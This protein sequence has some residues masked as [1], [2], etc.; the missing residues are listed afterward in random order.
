[1]DMIE[2]RRLKI[3]AYHGVLDEEREQGQDFYIS[4]KLYLD[5]RQA[6]MADD[7]KAT[8]N[9]DV[10]AHTIEKVVTQEKW[11]LIEA[12]AESVASEL[13]LQ[14]QEL[15]SVEVRVDKPEAPIELSF[16]TVSV[17]IKRGRHRA[18]LSIGSNLG[19]RKSYLDHAVEQMGKD[20]YIRVLK[21]AEYIET[22]PYGPVEQPDFLNGAVE[23]ETLYTPRELLQVLQDIEQEAGRKRIIHWGPRTLDMDILLY[24]DEVIREEGL[25]I[26]H[27]E[28]AKRLFVLEPL[29]SI[30]PEVVHPLYHRTAQELLEELKSREKET[31]PYATD[32][33]I[34][35]EELPEKEPMVCYAGVPGAYAEAAAIK[36]FGE[37]AGLLAVKSFDEVAAAV[38][39][40]K[41]DYGV[42]PV[43]NSSAGFVSGN[44]DIVRNSGAVILDEVVIDIE[45]ALL[46]LPNS[47]LS[48]IKKVYSHNQGLMQCKDYIER[49]GFKTEAVSNTAVAARKVME[50]GNVSCAA[51]A[52]ERA[53][54]LYN[55]KILARRINFSRD[56][57]T[58]FV[59]ISRERRVL[60]SSDTVIICF[61]A[62]H[63]V[64]SLYEIMG[65][66]NRNSINMTSIESRPSLKKKWEYIFYVCF[67]GK[68][69]DRHVRRVLGEIDRESEDF[70]VLGTFSS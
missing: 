35:S 42:I 60:T 6:S 13:L 27:V 46:G 23:I 1:M 62:P 53:A 24:D 54:E 67:E 21:S 41:A 29:V 51:I 10:A 18:Y 33:Y 38:M 68:L 39:E 32:G 40:G 48:D 66:I 69:T 63:R 28:M 70:R 36:Y 56:N 17:T 37:S 3:F 34:F 64:G 19:N 14:Y 8:V 52:S 44:M 61:S 58:R 5:L 43:E 59:I 16:E 20:P 49:N 31:V 50:G 30:A 11:N 4:A 55:L 25:I 12:V 7:L 2:I 26:P 45:H 57:A 65:I 15:R 22:E 9:Y 47:M